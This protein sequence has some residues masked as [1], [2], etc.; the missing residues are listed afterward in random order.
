MKKEKKPFN[1]NPFVI[2]FSVIVLCVIFSHIV[3]PGAFDR[4]IVDGRTVIV[5]GSFHNVNQP[6]MGFFDIFRAIPNGLIG[7]ASIV[8]LVLIVGGALEVYNQTGAINMGIARV[9]GRFGNKGSSMVLLIII[10]IFSLLGGF[11]GWI[12]P[13][14]PFIPLIV[15]IALAL[16]YDSI[17]GV[18]VSAVACMMAFSVGPT[19]MY[20]VGISHSIAELPMFSG[21]EFRLVVFAVIM[22]ITTAYIMR[23]AAKVKKDPSKSIMRGIDVTSLQKDYTQ[24]MNTKMTTNQVGALLILAGTFGVVIYGMSAMNWKINDMSAAFALSGLL[25]GIVCRMDANSIVQAFINGVKGS[26]TGALI[27]GVARGVQWVLET[28]MLVDPAIHAMSVPLQSLPNWASAIGI[29]VVVTFINA[30][31]PSG[32]GKAVA[33][34]PMLIPLSDLV[35]ITRQTAVLAYQFGDGISNL[36]WFTYGTMLI[37]LSAGKITITRW[38]RFIVPLLSIVFIVAAVF[39]VV[40]VK[41]GYGPF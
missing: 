11:L 14:I 19:N 4:T 36:L 5:E 40:A 29:F 2:I 1:P 23:Y 25:A 35:G 22:S 30:L 33:L 27:I 39:L 26:V 41:I 34:M 31:I 28:G 7:A 20:T 15:S 13:I 9:V 12:E 17:V 6:P 32:S 10:A 37:F 24:E 21:I 16:G 18:A 38:Y 8:F 3:E